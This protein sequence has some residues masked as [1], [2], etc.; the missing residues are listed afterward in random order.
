MWPYLYKK[1]MEIKQQ[2]DILLQ[3]YII[4]KK[5]KIYYY[6]KIGKYRYLLCN[7]L[8]RNDDYIPLEIKKERK[9]QFLHFDVIVI[10]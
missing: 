2:W 6:K 9:K 3:E 7:D 10:L 4:A 5:K 1:F 8:L